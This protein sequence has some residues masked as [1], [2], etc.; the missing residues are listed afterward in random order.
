MLGTHHRPSKA[1]VVH[2]GL[3]DLT[4][5]F[6]RPRV[7][8]RGSFAT[9]AY[10][11]ALSVSPSTNSI[12]TTIF[13]DAL[14]R[15][16]GVF[17][18]RFKLVFTLQIAANPFQQGVVALCW[19]Y[20]NGGGHGRYSSPFSATNLPHVRADL[21]VDTM[22]QLKVPYFHTQEFIALDTSVGYGTYCLTAITPVSYGA[23]AANASY[24]IYCH[25]EDLELVAVRPEGYTSVII[26]S[27]KPVNEE[28]KLSTAVGIVSKAVRMIGYGIPSIEWLAGPTSWFLEATSGAIRAFGYSKPMVI[29]VPGRVCPTSATMENNVDVPSICT[30]VGPMAS[31]ALTFGTDFS[32]TAV[33]EMAFGYILSQWGQ[34]FLGKLTPSSAA[35]TVV[36]TTNVSPSSFWF[37][38]GYS[39]TATGNKGPPVLS[40]ALCNSFFPSHV[41]NLAQHFRSWKGGFKFRI[42]VAKTKFHSGRLL[43]YFCPTSSTNVISD[44]T[45]AAVAPTGGQTFGHTKVFDLKDNNIFEFDVPYVSAVPYCEF[46]DSIGSFGLMVSDPL[47]SAGVVSTS[48]SFLV[49]VRCMDNFE[50]AIPRTPL[51]PIC[52]F[53]TV[54]VQS[55]SWEPSS[56]HIQSEIVST[57][58]DNVS[59]YTMGEKLM[60]VKQLLM[61]PKTFNTTSITS[62]NPYE[63]IIMMPWTHVRNVPPSVPGPTQ[64]QDFLFNTAGMLASCYLFA[65]GGTDVHAYTHGGATSSVLLA[66]DASPT[67]GNRLDTAP[68][69]PGSTTSSNNPRVI[70]VSNNNIHV[71]FPAYS[72]FIRWSTIAYNNISAP[73]LV[74]SRNIDLSGIVGVTP[75]VP[76]LIVNNTSTTLIHLTVLRAAADDAALCHYMGPV[77]LGLLSALSPVN[78][79]IEAGAQWK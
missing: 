23:G 24:T 21:S 32:N 35:T 28:R 27:G 11:T 20:N 64:F 8:A 30:T 59:Q 72:Q 13:P 31:N 19:Q 3:Q 51:Y 63:K 65:R 62:T 41:F 2:Q 74:G 55:G 56:I 53:G 67:D 36:Y 70:S 39:T 71:R 26:Q 6:K 76:R 46:L 78:L 22:V 73:F 77:P 29:D 42:T 12:F 45:T 25:M 49:E 57:I 5:Y 50:L 60:S 52:S 33:D 68:F 38:D 58:S 7:I 40:G 9:G 54:K 69:G 79:D 17:G 34:I 75:A 15:L 66:A 43:A 18:V 47:N 1:L 44:S 48:I 4:E 10:G 37:R 14:T 61:I 16:A